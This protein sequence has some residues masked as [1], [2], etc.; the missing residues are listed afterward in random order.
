MSIIVHKLFVLVEDE[1]SLESPLPASFGL[2]MG[3]VYGVLTEQLGVADAQTPW[4][5]RL[6]VGKGPGAR[7]V[8]IPLAD[9]IGQTVREHAKREPVPI[10]L[11][12]DQKLRQCVWLYRDAIWV[13]SRSPRNDTEVVEVGLR[14]KA[15]RLRED[16]DLQ[17]LRDQVANLEAVETLRNG[18][19]ARALIPDDVKLLVWARDGGVCVKCGSR[20]QLQF[21]HV[22]P[23]SRGGAD[24]PENLQILCRACNLAKSASLV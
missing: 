7:E 14:I 1:L 17:R 16:A 5:L 2:R 15:A 24:T 10:T 8:V 6:I 13:A 21:D 3:D 11:V 4:R 20:E 23:H 18:G 9:F 22:I 12:S 19:R